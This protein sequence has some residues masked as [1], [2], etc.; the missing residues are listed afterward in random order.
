MLPQAQSDQQ[1]YAQNDIVV[2]S[3]S[4]ITQVTMQFGDP[5]DVIIERALRTHIDHGEKWKYPTHLVRENILA[6]EDP[7][8]KP[9]NKLWALMKVMLTE[10]TKPRETRSDWLVYVLFRSIKCSTQ[11]FHFFLPVEIPDLIDRLC[12]IF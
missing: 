10:M 3:G 11:W 7:E 5:Y 6:V 12:F 8:K 4:R 2:E 1:Y 9:F